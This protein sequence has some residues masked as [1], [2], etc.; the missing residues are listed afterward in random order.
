MTKQAQLPPDAELV[1]WDSETTGFDPFSG[2][3]I[4]LGAVRFLPDGRELGRYQ[5]LIH[6]GRP[7]PR[8]AT[9]VHGITDRDVRD[10]PRLHEAL[11]GFLAFLG[12]ESSLLLAHNAEFDIRFLGAALAQTDCPAPKH[13]VYD[14]L[15]LARR[16]FPGAGRRTLEAI[17]RHLGLGAGVEH[18]AL[19]DAVMVKHLVV[20]ALGRTLGDNPVESCLGRM[21]PLH[22]QP[23][24][25]VP[26]R[27]GVPAGYEWLDR[28][29]AKR[30]VVAILYDGGTQANVPRQITPQAVIQRRGIVFIEAL[31]H[32]SQ[33]VK[34]FQL[35]RIRRCEAPAQ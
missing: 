24:T 20:Q 33:I 21:T 26:V 30:Q 10:Q 9:A 34:T 19:S 12:D 7:I 17:A 2:G 15:R 1:A 3:L 31:C 8:A 11:P 13:R 25:R 14:T 29:L 32:N 27:S 5:Q 16:Y 6:P 18:R 28:A 23:L 4:E 22:I 35:S